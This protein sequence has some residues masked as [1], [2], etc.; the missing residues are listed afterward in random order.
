M[1]H[2][3]VIERFCREAKVL[4]NWVG[5]LTATNV[6]D[7]FEGTMVGAPG[8]EAFGP[9]YFEWIDLLEAILDVETE[10]TMV[11]LGAGWGRWTVFAF[12]ALRLYYGDDMPH[13]RFIAVEPDPQHFQWMQSHLRRNSVH[14][15]KV[16]CVLVN[17]AI[18]TSD[19]S[20]AFHTGAS[21]RW[22]GQMFVSAEHP[23]G[24]P[25]SRIEEVRTVTLPTLLAQ[26][27]HVDLLDMDIQGAEFDVLASSSAVLGKIR[28]ISIGTHSRD[29]EASLR[30][31]MAAQGWQSVHDY[32][33]ATKNRTPYGKMDF[34][35]DGA[36]SWINP[37]AVCA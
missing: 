23:E 35:D 21:E 25:G 11:E 22:Y 12:S 9:E 36:Q 33:G 6:L 26:I 14:G 7:V 20:A 17:A 13:C 34:P 3:P 32:P 16:E 31:F 37:A 24:P 5:A 8:I 15:E 19:G 30:R 2:H 10:F 1:G 27:D 29:I 28:R 18:G 4:P